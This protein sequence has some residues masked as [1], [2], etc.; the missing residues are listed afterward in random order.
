MIATLN[1]IQKQKL[2]TSEERKA[3]F[4]I[5]LGWLSVLL[6]LLPFLLMTSGCTI[7]KGRSIAGRSTTIGLRI[8]PYNQLTSSPEV[9]LGYNCVE[10]VSVDEKASAKLEK[11]YKDIA[12]VTGKGNV[13]TLLSVGASQVDVNKDK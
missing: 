11:E 9:S 12:I 3:F 6:I 10:G 2:F 4:F 8:V 1:T 13:K 7:Q 5:G